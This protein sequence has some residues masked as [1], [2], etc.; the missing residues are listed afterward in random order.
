MCFIVVTLDIIT[1]GV[2]GCPGVVSWDLE[3]QVLPPTVA[4][5]LPGASLE[6]L[7]GP[8]AGLWRQVRGQV[9]GR[10]ELQSEPLRSRGAGC[11][12]E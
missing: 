2:S 7:S 9:P 11:R 4:P 8:V 6:G 10:S 5:L 1:N 12:R 3:A